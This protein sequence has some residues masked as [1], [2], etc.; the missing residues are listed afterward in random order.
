MFGITHELADGGNQIGPWL[1][2]WS[3]FQ[4]RQVRE[5][6]WRRHVA[7]GQFAK[8]GGITIVFLATLIG[9]VQPISAHSQN[10]E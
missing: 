8:K 5:A 3:T 10:A 2:V 7:F 6:T 1:Q 9:G 4:T